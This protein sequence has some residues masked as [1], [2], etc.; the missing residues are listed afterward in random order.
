MKNYEFYVP[1]LREWPRRWLAGF[2]M[3]AGKITWVGILPLGLRNER[4]LTHVER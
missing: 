1:P 2:R 4:E 3:L